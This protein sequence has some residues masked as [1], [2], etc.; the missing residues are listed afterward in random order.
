MKELVALATA[1]VRL[2]GGPEAYSLSEWL[3]RTDR[4]R[5]GAEVTSRSPAEGEMGSIADVVT[6]AIGS[7]GVLA[8]LIGK[9]HDWIVLRHDAGSLKVTYTR[10]DGTALEIEVDRAQN[11]TE[12]LERVRRII[13]S[14]DSSV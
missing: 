1:T 6:V 7:S 2:G 9:V 13:E 3:N 11:R 14:G 8:V 10:S 4:F 5:G 12:L